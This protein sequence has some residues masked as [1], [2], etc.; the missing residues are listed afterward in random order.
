MSPDAVCCRAA[1]KTLHRGITSIVIMAADTEP[2]EI[3]LHLPLLAE[4]KVRLS[5]HLPCDRC[6]PTTMS[7]SDSRVYAERPLCFCALQGGPWPRLRRDPTGVFSSLAALP[8]ASQTDTAS[9]FSVFLGMMVSNIVKFAAQLSA[10][11]DRSRDAD[12]S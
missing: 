11:Q 8:E 10:H 1:T 9:Q 6:P 4:D 12:M 7:D 2:I 5:E 3:L